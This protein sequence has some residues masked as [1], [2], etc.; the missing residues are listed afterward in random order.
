VLVPRIT[1]GEDGKPPHIL[2][3]QR[4]PKGEPSEAQQYYQQYGAHLGIF[5]SP[6]SATAYAQNLHNQQAALIAQNG[7]TTQPVAGAPGGLPAPPRPPL[8]AALQAQPAPASPA[9]PPSTTQTPSLGSEIKSTLKEVVSH[10]LEVLTGADLPTQTQAKQE[11]LE[12]SAQEGNQ[13]SQGTLA[14]QQREQQPLTNISGSKTF[15][16]IADPKS[17]NVFSRALTGGAKTI[18]ALS[19]PDNIML[20]G[21]IPFAPEDASQLISGVFSTQ[22]AQGAGTGAYDT[23]RAAHRGD[24]GAAAEAGANALLSAA[25]AAAAGK[26]AAGGVAAPAEAKP[27]LHG[28]NDV[29]TLRASAERQ[30]PALGDAAA[31]AAE[32]V[33]GA[34][35]EAVRDSKDSDRITDKAERQGVQPSQIADIAAAKVV[36]PDQ[37]AAEQVLTNLDKTMPVEK[38]DGMVTGEP[39][40]NAVRQVQAVVNTGA[41]GEPV[42]RAEVLLQTPEMAKVTEET[43][44]DYRKAQELRQQGK[45][46]EAEALEAQII[47]KHEAAEQ[48]AR[49]RQQQ[50]KEGE[51][52]YQ[53]GNSQANIPAGSAAATALDNFRAQI[54]DQH[55]AGDGKDI[56]A[57]GNHVT[58][59]YG[60][61]GDDTAGIRKFIES[62]PPFMARLGE[63]DVFPPTENSKG[64]AVVHARVES[65]ELTRLNDEIQQHG[66]FKESNFKDYK[67]HA[68]I[69]YIDPSQA[70][71]YKGRTDLKG[72]EFPVNSIAISDRN[73]NQTDVPLRGGADVLRERSAGGVVQPPQEEAGAAGSGRGG[74]EQGERGQETAAAGTEAPRETPAITPAQKADGVERMLVS[75]ISLDPKRFQY[76]MGTD[77]SGVTNLLKGRKWNEDLAGLISVWRDPEDGKVYTVNGH[78]RFQLA[79]ENGVPDVLV[80]KIDAP[81]AAA[82]RAVGALQN[83]AEGRGTAMD[84]AKF[85]RDSGY[86]PERLDDLGISMGEATAA[87]GV[88]LSR[89]DSSLFDQVVSG[90]LR[91][92]RAIAIGNA[93]ADPADQ[94]AIVKLIQKQEAKGR[95]VTDDVVDELARMVKGSQQTTETQQGLFGA[96]EMTRSLALEKAEISSAVREKIAQERRV[97]QSVADTGKAATLGKVKGQQLK[98]EVNAKIAREAGQ[99]QEIYDRLSTRGGTIDDILNRAARELADGGNANGIKQRAY[100]D[101]R[102]EL[103]KAVPG[104][105]GGEREGVQET[106]QARPA[107]SPPIPPERRAEPAGRAATGAAR[108]TDVVRPPKP[109][110]AEFKAGSQSTAIEVRGPD[111]WRA[112]TL[113]YYNDGVN[114]QA[115]R[116]RVTLADGTK[117]NNVPPREMRLPTKPRYVGPD[118]KKGSMAPV[119][120]SDREK[121]IIAYT[122][123]NMPKLVHQYLDKHTVNGVAT[124]ATDAAKEMYPDFQKDPT[125]NEREVHTS[126]AAVAS[127]A[128]NTELAEPVKP[129]KDV[130]DI[131]TASPGSGKTYTQ[132]AEATA[133]IGLRLEDIMTDPKDASIL[134]DKILASGR[135]PI[136]NWIYVD[137][138]QTTV[139]RMALRAVGHDGKPGIGR[140]VAIDYMA[141]AYTELPKTLL[142]LMDKY[143]DKIEVRGIDNSGAKADVKA[144][145]NPRQTLEKMGQ[146]KQDVVQQQMQERLEALKQQGVFDSEKGKAIYEAANSTST[147]AASGEAGK[148]PQPGSGRAPAEDAGAA[149]QAGGGG[150][151][152]RGQVLSDAANRTEGTSGRV[153]EGRST[154]PVARAAAPGEGT[155]PAATPDHET[156]E[157]EA[158]AA[159]R[160][161]Q[162]KAATD[163]DQHGNAASHKSTVETIG[164]RKHLVL[165]ADG[166]G[167]WHRLFG[168][169]K[170]TRIGKM[171]GARQSWTGISLDKTAVNTALAY[172]Q[173]ATGDLDALGMPDE[174]AKAGYERMAKL[175]REARNEQGGATILRGDYRGD[176]AREEAWHQWQREHGLDHSD[177]LRTVTEL[178]EFSDAIEKLREMDD[179]YRDLKP[180]TLA[181]EAM[182]KAIAGDPAFKITDAQREGMVRSF[183]TEAVEEHGPKILQNL[184]EADSRLKA[185]VNEVRRGYDYGDEY[186]QGAEGRGAPETRGVGGQTGEE[187]RQTDGGSRSILRRGP[188]ERADAGAE[189]GVP[190]ERAAE[191]DVAFQRSKGG[192]VRAEDSFA[193]PGM[194]GTDE[195]RAQAAGEQ[196][197]LDLTDA[198][199]APAKDISA[200]AGRMER[201]SPLFFGTGA[202]G[203]DTLFQ[204]APA[205]NTPEF[206]KWFGDSKVS[207]KDGE[208]L[209]LYHGTSS[210]FTEFGGP[211]MYFTDDPKYTEFFS[212]GEGTTREGGRT[213]PVYV[214][215]EHPLDALHF[216]LDKITGKQFADAIHAPV[217]S[218]ILNL[219]ER[220]FWNW[221]RNNENSVRNFLKKAGYDGVIQ[222]ESLGEANNNRATTAYV[223]FEPNQI[224]SAVGNRGTFDETSPNI[225]YQHARD[226]REA[227][228]QNP[229]FL[230]SARILGEKMKGPMPGDALVRM[231]ENNGVKA[232]ELKWSGLEDLKG[233]ARVTPDEVK[234]HLAEN[235]ITIKE[236]MNQEHGPLT[237]RGQQGGAPKFGTYTLPGGENYREMLLTLPQN[238]AGDTYSAR[239]KEISEKHGGATGSDLVA[240][241]TPEESAELSRLAKAADV[242]GNNRFKSGHWD[243][244][245]VLAHIRFNDRTTPD[246]KKLLHIEEIQ[247]D[248]HQKGRVLGYAGGPD[249]Y[250]NQIPVGYHW[251]KNMDRYKAAVSHDLIKDSTGEVV[252]YGQLRSEALK[253]AGLDHPLPNAP[254]AK[255]WHEMA[256]RRAVKYAA[257]NGYDGVSWTPGEQQAARYDLSKQ[258]S[259]IY[260]ERDNDTGNFEVNAYGMGVPGQRTRVLDEDQV[261]P[262]KLADMVGKDLAN[263]IVQ[264]GGTRV[265]ET[266]AT[267]GSKY[268]DWH[269]LSGLDLKV[270]GEGMKGFYNKILP[271]YARKFG[272]QWGAKLGETGLPDHTWHVVEGERDGGEKSYRIED[273]NGKAPTTDMRYYARESAARYA[274]KLTKD[275]TGVT[276]PVLDITPEMRQQVATEGVPLFQKAKDGE[277]P[278]AK[279]VSDLVEDLKAMPKPAKGTMLDRVADWTKDTVDESLAR[280]AKSLGGV[281]SKFEQAFAKAKAVSAALV[282]AITRPPETTDW[283][284][285]VGQMQLAQT[286][287]ALKLKDLADELKRQAP[288]PLDR[289][290]MTHYMEAG[291]KESKLKEWAAGNK[292][293]AMQAIGTDASK[294]YREAQA[295]YDQA[296]KLTPEQKQLA[297]RLR[298]HFDDM[299]DVAK[300]NGLLE[301]G[302]RNYVMHLYEKADA[303]NLLHMVDNSE[304]NPD[305]NFLKRRFYDTFYNAEGGGLTPKTK[306]IGH[307]LTAYDKSM[308][309]AIASR[310]FMRSLLDAKAPDGRPIAAIKTRG[311]WVIAKGDELPQVLNQRARPAT[312]E[313]YRDFDRP[314][315][316]NFLF[317]PTTAD[318]EGFDPKLFDED[319]EHLAFRGDLIIHPKFASQ[320]EDMLTPSWFER[321]E[322]TPQKIAQGVVKTSALAKEAMT[323]LAPFHMATEGYRAAE[324]WTSPFDVPKINLK[325]EKQRLLASHGLTLTNYNA[326]GLFSVKTLRGLF[327]PVPGL[328][329]MM[330]S[331]HNFSRWQFQDY[332]PRMKMQT[333]LK[334]FDKNTKSFPKLTQEQVAELTSRQVNASY[335]NLNTAFDAMPR[336]K[337]MKSLLRLT[338]FAPDFLESTLRSYGQALTRYGTQQRMSLVRG[339]LMLYATARIVNALNNNGDPKMDPEHAFTVVIGGREYNL[340]SRAGDLL[341]LVTDPRGFIYNRLNP[342]T[343]RPAVEYLSGRDQF[344]RQKTVMD[345]TKDVVKSV[346]PFAAQKAIQTPDET[347]LEGLLTSIGLQ[348]RN[349]RTP[350][351]ES[352]HKLYLQHLP[353]SPDD[354]EHEAEARKVRQV[355]DDMRAGKIGPTDVWAMVPDK[356]TP[357]EAAR[358]VERA[359]KSRLEIEYSSLG[360]KDAIKVYEKASPLEQAELRPA[361]AKKQALIAEQPEADREE[362]AERIEKL[363]VLN[364]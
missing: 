88:A 242:V 95:K 278:V 192:A 221:V 134:I 179:S 304:L 97:F 274:E 140:T 205:T 83:I 324:H 9:A 103:S 172:L 354:P 141:K 283:K 211:L 169:L 43:H 38:V 248:W 338:T 309:D 360:L 76:K 188:G 352:V 345:Q 29:E 201:E 52:R 73:G 174:G 297:Q 90:K 328:N 99:A 155:I 121:S 310:T 202:G 204:R 54:P 26:H 12:R 213:M 165:D 64:A 318:L 277:N 224:K 271:D 42:K 298:D 6:A 144:L 91:Q 50:P 255:D 256:F 229:W 132:S 133:Q 41:P 31:A 159:T 258:I 322:T 19:S 1:D 152:L 332:I 216:G 117:L 267:Y 280:S 148:E 10:P 89:L 254:F 72:A 129:G 27:V 249:G 325:D 120:G 222:K 260:Y 203:Q 171:M 30:A 237:A 361:L 295:H 173:S 329:K 279:S 303:A 240:K 123:E 178:P 276:V 239:Y 307:L 86:T 235:A 187:V 257:D 153:G 56:G 62:Q 115:P 11:L 215:M 107:G 336:T 136:I 150:S 316:R 290:A 331:V 79:Q 158:R 320:V 358:T 199:R 146:L 98:P 182:A 110:G 300:K 275:N 147:N 299:L 161:S 337:T 206:K 313:G 197:G 15:Q 232:D 342:L 17:K 162:L 65:P 305:P 244:P 268:R 184:P 111:G 196:Q 193:L 219:T 311:G 189:R 209:R 135:R 333:A 272:K 289:I 44:D 68:T 23:I 208:P 156:R 263:K 265:P 245:N 319:P 21:T 60:I 75:D 198:L 181:M 78:H 359:Q 261:T 63:T 301:Y 259:S 154:E 343:T 55:L 53:Y 145:E 149:S 25:M 230:K 164:G 340:R 217:D 84:A 143:G 190:K 273:E 116:G 46:A 18:D 214:K 315:L 137:D 128:L 253:M 96:Q 119:T 355:E 142:G 118:Q 36:V 69:A 349:Y 334:L 101:I 51:T 139:T 175:L 163:R 81:T 194:E 351:E 264:N 108:P 339:A 37:Q 24:Y 212:G 166:E 61:Q 170:D 292:A 40:K 231:L 348:A 92:G 167:V 323:F 364:Q 335:G 7:R 183:L 281:P 109:P 8:P 85:F 207:D 251:E 114:G 200:A 243:E 291:G 286:E 262:E 70:E 14:A 282:H 223:T 238:K 131:V 177:A 113:E 220:P 346:A 314:Q 126:A 151:D 288:K 344:G 250:G 218:S 186:N 270:G 105:A 353:D 13:L 39:G 228:K 2:N 226:D 127:A 74:V 57:G 35:V 28:S 47:Q 4:G 125:R 66:D 33:P 321:G 210:H 347:W 252:G 269:E 94:E 247:S 326:E 233:K 93:T 308:N 49:T 296:L 285:Q 58:V 59:R 234:Q 138:P 317:K 100:D 157:N 294:Y 176:T 312:L 106:P 67:P 32:P 80:K 168:N 77:K 246:G 327:E 363:L 22:M 357:R 102:A 87:N 191:G 356:L 34:K 16:Q 227:T 20:W 185:V 241:W 350:T 5:D 306:D 330:D 180:N 362:L 284:T 287:T 71:A 124:I 266:S 45:D 341:H 302:Y 104:G 195:E 225:L 160:K 130:V 236:V 122:K 48:A 112:A 3:D 293:R 82:A